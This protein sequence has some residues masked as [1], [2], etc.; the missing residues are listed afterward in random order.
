M[1][2][3]ALVVGGFWVVYL[4]FRA[5]SYTS[6]AIEVAADQRVVETGPYAVLRHPMYA[7]AGILLLG[8]GVALGTWWAVAP[9]VALM[10]AIVWRLLDEERFLSANLPGY[11]AYRLRTRYR[12]IPGVW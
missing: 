4:T 11:D 10:A 8:S 6:A 12:L 5:N 9:A 1:V 2:G 7:G 3:D